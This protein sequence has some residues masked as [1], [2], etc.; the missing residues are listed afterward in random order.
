MCISLMAKAKTVKAQSLSTRQKAIRFGTLGAVSVGALA[1]LKIIYDKNPLLFR[2]L[3][4]MLWSG[5]K[6][7]VTG[8]VSGVLAKGLTALG[9]FDLLENV[10]G[11]KTNEMQRQYMI[12]AWVN[13]LNLIGFKLNYKGDVQ[14]AEAVQ[15][16]NL[17]NHGL[18]EIEMQEAIEPPA[19]TFEPSRY[20]PLVVPIDIVP[21]SNLIVDTSSMSTNL[22]SESSSTPTPKSQVITDLLESLWLSRKRGPPS[23]L[24][25]ITKK[26]R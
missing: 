2:K 25:S 15:Q 26:P 5:S 22:E 9:V 11:E 14:G 3:I 4:N 19:N 20:S 12:N 24:E 23:P 18:G 21:R 17:E 13:L 1:L 6:T 10:T 7:L 8:G 16:I